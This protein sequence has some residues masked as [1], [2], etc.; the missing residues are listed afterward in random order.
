MQTVGRILAVL[1]ADCLRETFEA[2]FCS[3]FIENLSRKAQIRQIGRDRK[4]LHTYT[5][6][7]PKK[8]A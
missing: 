6:R 2:T 5:D 8:I 7:M 3:N 1:K 4:N